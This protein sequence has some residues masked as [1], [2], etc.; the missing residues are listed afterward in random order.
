MESDEQ[1]VIAEIKKLQAATF[2]VRLGNIEV[3]ATWP[4]LHMATHDEFL[5][6]AVD[7]TGFTPED[8][9]DVVMRIMEGHA[10]NGGW[11]A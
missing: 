9:S 7:W 6:K 11:T 1:R 5:T 4:E 3:E 10:P 2:E 8:R